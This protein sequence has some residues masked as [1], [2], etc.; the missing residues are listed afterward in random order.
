MRRA[1]FIFV[2]AALVV[3]CASQDVGSSSSSVVGGTWDTSLGPTVGIFRCT[4]TCV[5]TP[6][7]NVDEICSGTLIA[8]NLVLTARHCVAPQIDADAGVLCSKSTF[9]AT[10][11][12]A[13]FIITPAKDVLE[14]GPWDIARDVEVDG[15]VGDLVCGNDVAVLHLRQPYVGASP[16]TPRIETPP[17]TKELYSAIGYGDDLDG[18]IGYRHRRD[19]LHVGCVGGACK[20][21]GPDNAPV[22]AP[23]EFQGDTGL[24]GGDSGGPAVDATGLLLGVT[25]RANAANCTSPVYSR[26]DAHAAW[27]EREASIAATAGGYEL[28]PWA[29]VALPSDAGPEAGPSFDASLP[30]SPDSSTLQTGKIEGGGCAI[31][32]G[33]PTNDIIWAVLLLR[34]LRR[35]PRS[36]H[37]EEAE[38]VRTF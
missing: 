19:N 18:G 2:V 7:L 28:P 5:F 15:N 1:V 37:A 13:N 12:A 4:G 8:P 11:P 20:S 32:S 9:G 24:C 36:S 31:A 22:I 3:A 10:Y 30:T 21:V 25:S 35:R 23:G 33:S 34:F 26:V 17:V 6:Y 27:L 38:P 29:Y 14:G 16:M